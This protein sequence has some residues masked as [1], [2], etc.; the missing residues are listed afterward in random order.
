MR[1][2]MQVRQFGDLH[3]N[4]VP[5][6]TES[7]GTGPK[8]RILKEDVKAWTKQQLEDSGKQSSSQGLGFAPMPEIDFS[9]FGE[10]EKLFLSRIK[11]LSGAASASF[12]G[13]HSACNPS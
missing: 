8:G 10:T 12:L 6:C 1:F 11:K 4:L 5:A 2:R 3:V 7:E 13:K 9:E